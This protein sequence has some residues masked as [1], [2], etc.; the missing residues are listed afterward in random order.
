MVWVSSPSATKTNHIADLTPR[1][2][3]FFWDFANSFL[4]AAAGYAIH[5]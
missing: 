5:E 3:D 4:C 2:L 1:D